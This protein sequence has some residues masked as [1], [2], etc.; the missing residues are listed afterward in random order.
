MLNQDGRDEGAGEAAVEAPGP[1]PLI[2]VQQDEAV[3]RINA[4]FNGI[5]TCRAPSAD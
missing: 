2:G 1:T 4:Y 3:R 5:T